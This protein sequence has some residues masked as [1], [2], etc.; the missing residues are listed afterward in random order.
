[1]QVHH[2]LKEE[3]GLEPVAFETEDHTSEQVSE[4]LNQYLHRATAAVI[5]MTGDEKTIENRLLA[6]QNVIHE[7]GLF[8]AKLGFHRVALLKE[9][10]VESFS[11]AQGLIYISFD[12]QNITGS[13]YSL[14]RFLAKLGI[15]SN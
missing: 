9:K 13:F 3:L 12:P 2:Y 14:R 7:A 15:V 1:M 10:G 8:Q 4:I 11:N 5:V 6:R